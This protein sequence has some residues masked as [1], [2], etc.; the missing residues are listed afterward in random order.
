MT[1]FKIVLVDM[2]SSRVWTK[3]KKHNSNE[4]QEIKGVPQN[5]ASHYIFIMVQDFYF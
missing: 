5:K 4:G 2:Q 1:F 3:M